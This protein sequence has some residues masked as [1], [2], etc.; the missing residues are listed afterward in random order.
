MPAEKPPSAT[1]KYDALGVKARAWL[2]AYFL[3]GLN[4]TAAS[5][6]MGYAAPEQ[7]GLRMSKNV[8]VLDA[9]EE[10]LAAAGMG[11]T[12][13]AFLLAEH[14][15]GTAGDFISFSERR[16]RPMVSV[17]VAESIQALV[18]DIQDAE[19]ILHTVDVDAP[20]AE[21]EKSQAGIRKLQRELRRCELLHDRQPEA[22][23]TVRGPEVVSYEPFV[24]LYRMQA[25]GKMHL[26]K[27][28]SDSP[29]AGLRVELYDAQS[30]LAHLARALGMFTDH[31]DLTSGGKALSWFD[32]GTAGLPAQSVDG[33]GTSDE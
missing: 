8:G 20:T 18:V 10:R 22:R 27:S 1:P 33:D 14:A 26:V 6:S 28:F 21:R 24:D 19:D 23:V 17:P 5:R 4:K 7:H 16:R 9:V 15:M 30:A 29:E 25:A 13:V 2:D 31:V 3:H 11:A 32:P 12:M